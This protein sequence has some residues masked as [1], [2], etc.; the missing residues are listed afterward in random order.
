[1]LTVCVG[2]CGLVRACS[3]GNCRRGGVRKPCAEFG[4]YAGR[5]TYPKEIDAH[6]VH[7]GGAGEAFLSSLPSA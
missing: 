4:I 5:I 1:M 6:W 2:S 3:S 7:L